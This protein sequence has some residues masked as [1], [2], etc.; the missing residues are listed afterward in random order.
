[1]KKLALLLIAALAA[2]VMS[3]G[4]PA[5][6]PPAEPAAP[7][8]VTASQ[9]QAQAES[10]IALDARFAGH[11]TERAGAIEAAPSFD[12]RYQAALA[13]GQ[14]EVGARDYALWLALTELTQ[15]VYGW[16]AAI[17]CPPNDPL[18]V[19]LLRRWR[20]ET[21][22][23]STYRPGDG[24]GSYLWTGPEGQPASEPSED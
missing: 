23:C 10:Y 21:I 16:G 1:M 18:Y 3:A 8:A 2:P 11:L 12:A 24:R 7:G 9:V 13:G 6:A 4:P 15:P 5:E 22:D 14:F 19:V 20:G 17:Y